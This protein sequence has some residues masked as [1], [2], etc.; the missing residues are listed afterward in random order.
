MVFL[1]QILG[2]RQLKCCVNVENFN[3]A[4][5][6]VNFGRRP[7]FRIRDHDRINTFCQTAR[8]SATRPTLHNNLDRGRF[9]RSLKNGSR[10]LLKGRDPV[11]KVQLLLFG[12]PEIPRINSFVCSKPGGS[13]AS[14]LFRL[15][16]VLQWRLATKKTGYS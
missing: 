9:Q 6:H 8:P 3:P 11:G 10:R 7:L 5:K 15:T 13:A 14:S 12:F 2:K 16:P 4:K 1:E